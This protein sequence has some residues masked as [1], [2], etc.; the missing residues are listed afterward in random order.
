MGNRVHISNNTNKEFT[1]Q[2]QTTLNPCTM[3]KKK[4]VEHE[5][6]YF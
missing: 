6:R 5:C 3:T 1:C 4:T 2:L